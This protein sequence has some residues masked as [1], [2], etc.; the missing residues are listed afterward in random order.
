MAAAAAA[1]RERERH[2]QLTDKQINANKKYHP[3]DQTKHEVRGY[4]RRVMSYVFA[5]LRVFCDLLSLSSSFSFLLPPQP[6]LCCAAPLSPP[7]TALLNIHTIAQITLLPIR[8]SS[9]A[10]QLALRSMP[11]SQQRTPPPLQP[12]HTHPPH[13]VYQRDRSHTA[14]AALFR[15]CQSRI[16]C[17]SLALSPLRPERA[18]PISRSHHRS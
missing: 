7:H 10:L 11:P 15:L 8:P 13:S 6:P 9:A 12:H 18:R 16:I 14:A 3:P 1:A 5:Q 2:H 17:L 4:E